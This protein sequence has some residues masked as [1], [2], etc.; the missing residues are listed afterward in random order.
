[1]HTQLLKTHY[2]ASYPRPVTQATNR[3]TS[4]I[5]LYS[6]IQPS[7]D[8]HTFSDD[9]HIAQRNSHKPIYRAVGLPSFS[10]V[11]GGGG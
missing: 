11:L 6:M 5:M 10:M 1:M 2:K 9:S 4:P 7:V 8:T 3:Y